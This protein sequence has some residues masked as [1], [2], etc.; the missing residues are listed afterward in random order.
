[1]RMW[2]VLAGFPHAR[3]CG[4]EGRIGCIRVLYSG[5]KP[6]AGRSGL[7]QTDAV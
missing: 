7:T 4:A 3:V 6:D 5:L 1:L 2:L